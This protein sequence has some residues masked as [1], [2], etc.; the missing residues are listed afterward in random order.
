MQEDIQYDYKHSFRNPKYTYTVSLCKSTEELTNSDEWLI[1][2]CYSDNDFHFLRKDYGIGWTHKHGWDDK[3]TNLDWS[4]N[5]ITHPKEA[6]LGPYDNSTL[7]YLKIT[8]T[9]N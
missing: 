1:A 5:I 3:P 9:K 2:Y 7:L 6:N 8:R 4:V